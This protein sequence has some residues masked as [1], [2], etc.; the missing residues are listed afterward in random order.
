MID[1]RNILRG[2][3][4]TLGALAITAVTSGTD[5]AGA[6][7]S[8]E[9]FNDPA[10]TSEAE[11]LWPQ[12]LTST[13]RKNLETFDELDFVVYSR[14]EWERLG[15]S[16]AQNIRVHYP[17]GH[18]TDGLDAHIAELAPMFVFAPDTRVTEHPIRIAKENLTAV[19]GVF[20]GTFSRPM[21]D[22]NGGLIQPTG[23]KFALNMVTVGI[24]NRRGVMDEEFLFWD[25]LAFMQQIGLA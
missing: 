25:N 22:G 4:A 14:Q 10:S 16:H 11:S 2:G 17:D 24:W 15:E 9:F 18:I 8:H 21:P 13:E 19:T 3:G 23:K 6:A 12:H 7:A 20:T 5:L 1:R